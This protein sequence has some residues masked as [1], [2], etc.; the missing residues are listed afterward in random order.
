MHCSVPGESREA[1]Q[2]PH[3]SDAHVGEV[4]HGCY[5]TSAPL[6][7]RETAIQQRN[8]EKGFFCSNHVSSVSHLFV[9]YCV[10]LRRPRASSVSE[11]SASAG[12]V[13]SLPSGG[14]APPGG[15]G[16]NALSL[17]H[18]SLP[19]P[20]DDDAPSNVRPCFPPSQVNVSL[21]ED[22][23][24]VCWRLVILLTERVSE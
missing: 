7:L 16:S 8:I 9:C 14:A 3:P 19:L 6:L 23:R 4:S 15:W 18:G 13:S 20:W 24:A 2:L 22:T 21:A 17:S 10:T 12:D 11:W 5:R 1:P